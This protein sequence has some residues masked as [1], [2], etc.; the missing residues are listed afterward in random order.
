VSRDR[1]SKPIPMS[2]RRLL[3]LAGLSAAAL[4]AAAWSAA[5]AAADGQLS[6]QDAFQRAMA[7]DRNI[8]WYG[9]SGREFWYRPGQLLVSRGDA[10][11]VM[12]WLRAAGLPFE[13]GRGFAGVVRL[14]LDHDADIP[15]IVTK[16]RDEQQWRGELAPAVQP[17]HVTIGF[18]NIM[19]NPD[20]AP[21]PAP[22]PAPPSALRRGDGKGV[23]VGICDTGIWRYAGAFHPLWLLGA[24]LPQVDDEDALYVHDDVLALQAGHGT[25]VAGVLRQTA[26]AVTFDPEA[27]LTAAGV[28]DEE[29]LVNA[30]DRL[31]RSVSIISLSLGCYTQDDVPPLPIVNQLAALR[32]DIVVVAAAG[33][34]G[35]SRP[36]WPAALPTVLSVAAVTATEGGLT[37]AGY[38]NFGP[39]VNAC[40]EGAWVSTY[41][42]GQMDL[43]SKTPLQFNGFAQWSGTSFATPYVAG[44]LAAMM[45]A[46]GYSAAQAAQDLL[47]GPEFA[48]GYGALAP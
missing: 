20:A 21:L 46:K 2:R 11:R 48:P 6:Y 4:P 5:P 37:P 26:P 40:A 16:L 1:F 19:G 43:M 24:Y 42:T 30:I 31:D 10:K 17:H 36:T 23:V 41:V 34:S 27:A 47:S 7:Q 33:N 29:M 14:L 18:G 45:T 32:K 3:Q 44:R 8:R 22:A 15:S 28:G 12:T 35:R 13:T 39:W 9:E 38:S 25:F